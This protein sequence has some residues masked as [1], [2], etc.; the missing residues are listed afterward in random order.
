[1]SVDRSEPVTILRGILMI[2]LVSNTVQNPWLTFL[3]DVLGADPLAGSEFSLVTGLNVDGF[4]VKGARS[5][6]T[7]CRG[8]LSLA[9]GLTPVVVFAALAEV[10]LLSSSELRLALVQLSL[11]HLEVHHVRVHSVRRLIVSRQQHWL[12]KVGGLRTEHAGV[13]GRQTTLK[14]GVSGSA[15]LTE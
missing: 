5:Q 1:M 3:E 12:Q 13:D 14:S 8:D 10:P 2:S 15:V 4:F 11:A 9:Q 6:T 7:G